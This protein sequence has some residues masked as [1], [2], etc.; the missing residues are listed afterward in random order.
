M[1]NKQPSQVGLFEPNP[2]QKPQYKIV[3]IW[4]I[5][6]AIVTVVFHV[7]DLP[8][9]YYV[10]YSNISLVILFFVGW[11]QNIVRSRFIILLLSVVILIVA[12]V[13]ASF[14]YVSQ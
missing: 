11:K 7:F 14:V 2:L 8:D 1:K 9:G 13:I 10:L 6:F 5:A 4:A 12:M 3:V